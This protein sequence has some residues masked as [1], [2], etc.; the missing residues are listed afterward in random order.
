MNTE[1]TKLEVARR[2]LGTALALFLEDKDPVA[3]HVLTCG[4]G[5]IAD[6]LAEVAGAEPFE[7][8][9]LATFPEMN[10]GKLAVLRKKHWNA[11]KHATTHNGKDR[12]DA[13]LLGTFSDETNDHHLF[14][15]W[16]DF[17]N[18]GGRLPIEAQAFQAWYF[19]KHPDKLSDGFDP[20]NFTSL[21]PGLTQVDRS[22]QKAR[23]RR[24]IQRYR[25]HRDIMA[26]SKTDPRPLI[27]GP[28]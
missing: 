5:E 22:Q 20:A 3:V 23:L 12:N 8:H 18:A 13:E 9:V 4:G 16:Y 27:L 26:D 11:L 21:F 10:K 14:I 7:T 25:R 24:V 19:A 1:L 17:A 28:F 2:Q 15:G 6:R